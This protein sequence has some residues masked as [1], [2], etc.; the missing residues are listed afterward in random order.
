MLIKTVAIIYLIIF[1]GAML[2]FAIHFGH[3][4]FRNYITEYLIV[5]M[6]LYTAYKSMEELM[7][8]SPRG[9]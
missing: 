8:G 1:W 7:I 4:K 3:D 9:K 5:S 2:T 6:F